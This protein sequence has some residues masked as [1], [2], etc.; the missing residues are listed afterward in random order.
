ML[1]YNTEPVENTPGGAGKLS[2][3]VNFNNIGTPAR[4]AAVRI[5]DPDTGRVVAESTTD[6]E[7]LIPDVELEAPPAGYSQEPDAPR[8]FNQYDVSVSPPGD[9]APGYGDFFVENVQIYPDATAVQNVALIPAGRD[10]LIPYPTLWGDYPPKIPESEIK[11][12]PFADDT[13]V[14]PEPVVPEFI[15]VHAGRPSDAS[16]PNY[17]VGFRDY[18]KNV[19]S[20][21]IYAT[22]PRAALEANILAIL[23]FT[24]NRVYTEWYRSRGYAFTV[25]S[26]TAYDQSFTYGRNVYSEISDVV[27]ELFTTYIS[28]GGIVQPLFTQYCDG[29][30]VS[31]Q[32]WLSQ[33]GSKS[34]AD[35]GMTAL[36]ILRYY[37]GS[38]ISLRQA[39]QVDGVPIS[40]PGLLEQGSRGDG[41]R[42]VQ[43]Q[44][45]A[46]SGNYPAIR[47]LA[48]DG[49]YGPL[50]EASVREFQRIFGQDVTGKVNFPTWYE[51]SRVYTAVTGLAG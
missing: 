32:G 21:E 4:G 17:T 18:V 46:V 45:N 14:L 1:D 26:S 16:A 35:R 50:T 25:T 40:F 9:A 22:W 38:D 37:Y 42:T 33:W 20:S 36:Q 15:V 30:E 13:A 41:V 23:S 48:V 24:M 12:L 34:L 31:R 29:V 43:S 2:V 27:D 44:L 3:R 49:I 28:R 10:V 47:R 11:S 19:A 8:P 7:G 5:S 6:A 39:P 51:L